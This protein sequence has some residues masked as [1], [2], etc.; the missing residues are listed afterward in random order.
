MTTKQNAAIGHTSVSLIGK[1]HVMMEESSLGGKL[2]FLTTQRLNISTYI[3]L[4]P[5][6]FIHYQ[7]CFLFYQLIVIKYA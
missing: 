1:R 3:Q 2:Y 5:Q 4:F 6:K 7:F